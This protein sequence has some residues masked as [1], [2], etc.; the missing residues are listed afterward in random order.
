MV[1]EKMALSDTVCEK[2]T[3]SP[4]VREKEGTQCSYL[5]K[6]YARKASKSNSKG[7]SAGLHDVTRFLNDARHQIRM[8]G[9]G[10]AMLLLWETKPCHIA[11]E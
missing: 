7:E 3:S 4:T 5:A 6:R 2:V 8:G 9:T 1:R 10:N 11:H